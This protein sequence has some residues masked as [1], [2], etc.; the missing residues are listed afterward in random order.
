VGIACGGFED[1]PCNTNSS[2][3]L[4]LPWRPTTVSTSALSTEP[5]TKSQE[6]STLPPRKQLL[7]RTVLAYR[8]NQNRTCHLKQ[9]GQ[10][11]VWVDGARRGGTARRRKDRVCLQPTNLIPSDHTLHDDTSYIA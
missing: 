6:Q 1:Q 3:V 5:P 7:H 4:E 2:I 9:K 10:I 8:A 11:S